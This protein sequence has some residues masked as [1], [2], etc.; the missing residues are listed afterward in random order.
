LGK[1]VVDSIFQRD[2]DV[3]MGC[4][5]VSGLLFVFVNLVVD[6]LYAVV[7]PRIRYD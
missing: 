7:D 4:L 2:Y 1:V 6:V 5:L 3:L